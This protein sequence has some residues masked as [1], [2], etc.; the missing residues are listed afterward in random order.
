MNGYKLF[1][2]RMEFKNELPMLSAKMPSK[3]VMYANLMTAIGRLEPSSEIHRV[4]NTDYFAIDGIS[5][6]WSEHERL[7]SHTYNNKTLYDVWANMKLRASIIAETKKRGTGDIRDTMN[8]MGFKECNTFNPMIMA[9]AFVN[10]FKKE[11][12]KNIT[13][14]DPSAGWGD[15]LITAIALGIGHY[16]GFDPNKNLHPIYE[17]IAADLKSDTA[18]TLYDTRFKRIKGFTVDVVFTSPPFYNCE[19][20]PGTEKDV[21]VSYKKWLCNMYIPYIMDAISMLKIGGLFFIYVHNGK[22]Y[23]LADDT[24]TIMKRAKMQHIGNIMFYNTY[25]SYC[26]ET[27]EGKPRPMQIWKR[28]E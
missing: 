19:I 3:E 16:I 6:L 9:Q 27:Y 2:N 17:K 10:Y 13:I 24:Q 25:I 8:A 12:L 20:Y 5:N 11:E 1:I 23:M 18:T 7:N 15:R 14:L 4:Y 21:Q 22:V 26:G 28:V